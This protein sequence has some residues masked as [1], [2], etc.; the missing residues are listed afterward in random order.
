[1]HTQTHATFSSEDIPK[2]NPEQRNLTS[3]MLAFHVLNETPTWVNLR[4]KWMQELISD[5]Y[6]I[7][8]TI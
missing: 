7:G 4:E 3:I 5:K 6:N 1:M 8:K 2:E